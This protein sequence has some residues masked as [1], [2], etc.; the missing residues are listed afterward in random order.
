[1]GKAVKLPKTE[2]CVSKPRCSRCPI[3]MLKDGDLPEGFEVHRRRL[4]RVDD[5][6]RRTKAKKSQVAAAMKSGSSKGKKKA[7]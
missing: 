2:C 7:A 6:G 5:K 3:R 4:V 1:M